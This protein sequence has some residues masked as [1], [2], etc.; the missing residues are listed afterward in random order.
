MLGAHGALCGLNV[1]VVCYA[2][3]LVMMYGEAQPD[4]VLYVAFV[5]R[6]AGVCV[7]V[8]IYLFWI[9]SFLF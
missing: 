9:C 4:I 2:L 6:C 8:K 3:R 5:P 7:L 1:C